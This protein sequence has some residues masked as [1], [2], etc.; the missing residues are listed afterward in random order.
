MSTETLPAVLSALPMPA[1]LPSRPLQD[2]L[3]TSAEV[4][5]SVSSATD[6]HSGTAGT[7]ASIERGERF[8]ALCKAQGGLLGQALEAV[9]VDD[10]SRQLMAFVAAWPNASGGD[11]AGYGAQL[12]QDVVERKPCR[13]ALREA[14]R[15]LRYKCKFLPSIAETLAALDIA[16]TAMRNTWWHLT[17]L[18]DQLAKAQEALAYAERRDAERSKQEAEAVERRVAD[19]K[20]NAW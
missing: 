6:G 20:S 16:Q 13:Y 18:P 8:L 7:R 14:L 2:I 9:P 3:A 17:T 5:I 12:V 10:I 11:L 15:Q 19:G 4:W 1:T